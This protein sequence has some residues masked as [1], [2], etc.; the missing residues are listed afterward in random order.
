MLKS[1]L[2]FLKSHAIATGIATTVIVGSAGV[3]IPIAIESYILDK[4]VKENL[5]LL[6]KK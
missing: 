5:S 4:N 6:E 3:G 1:I 2:L